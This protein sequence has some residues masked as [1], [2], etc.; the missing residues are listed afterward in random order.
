MAFANASIK[1][2]GPIWTEEDGP[3][4]AKIIVS[5]H[6]M[7]STMYTAGMRYYI[8]KD[9]LRAQSPIHIYKNAGK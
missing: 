5:K 9:S 7:P 2:G 6:I 1:N 4:A 3:E 8:Q